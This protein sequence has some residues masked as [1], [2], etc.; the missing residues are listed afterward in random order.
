MTV[1]VTNTRQ[2]YSICLLIEVHKTTCEEHLAIDPQSVKPDL[3][4][5]LQGIRGTQ[6]QVKVATGK[7]TEKATLWEISRQAWK[8]RGGEPGF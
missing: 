1:N 8:K 5:T 2:L 6:K 3:T 7:Q 4:T